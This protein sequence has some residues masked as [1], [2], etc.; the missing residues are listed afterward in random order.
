MTPSVTD[1]DPVFSND[2]PIAPRW[3]A[4]LLVWLGGLLTG[5]SLVC[6]GNALGPSG[7]HSSPSHAHLPRWLVSELFVL[8]ISGLWT[9]QAFQKASPAKQRLYRRGAAKAGSPWRTGAYIA[10]AAALLG[11]LILSPGFGHIHPGWA[12]L[13]LAIAM[14]YAGTVA[15]L[16]STL[17]LY[18]PLPADLADAKSPVQQAAAPSPALSIPDA[19]V[20]GG[21]VPGGYTAQNSK[22]VLALG[23]SDAAARSTLQWGWAARL[24]VWLC[25]IV[26]A[27]GFAM[28]ATS[29][30]PDP[31]AMSLHASAGDFIT[32]LICDALLGS[33]ISF[34]FVLGKSPVMLL[35]M[36]RLSSKMGLPLV[37]ALKIAGGV[38][39]LV[40]VVCLMGAAFGSLRG[41]MF[42]HIGRL[43]LGFPL[44]IA[45]V[46]GM[47]LAFRRAYPPL[48]AGLAGKSDEELAAAVL[49]SV[50]KGVMPNSLLW[51]RSDRI[52]VFG[53]SDAQRRGM[54]IVAALPAILVA[55]VAISTFVLA[56]TQLL[57]LHALTPMV[58][59]FAVGF[60]V[61]ALVMA[62]GIRKALVTKFEFDRV[63]RTYHQ[64]TVDSA[65]WKVPPRRSETSMNWGA[66]RVFDG[67]V[68]DDM[69]GV[70]LSVQTGGRQNNWLWYQVVVAWRDDKHPAAPLS[71]PY[72][73]E[74]YAISA[75]DNIAAL[76][77]VPMLGELDIN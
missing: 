3:K 47:L 2:A 74:A 35:N 26:A 42:P 51:R 34:A 4:G 69:L 68:D 48:T 9:A 70:G 71:Q 41:P 39:A 14:L 59:F 17:L 67:A 18:P 28:I 50:Y 5:Q 16:S 76:L 32:L 15:T 54:V 6:L 25:S 36:R 38:F 21:V 46:C 40:A 27:Q 60:V 19:S 1:A 55:G 77:G 52:L 57:Q 64:V 61:F 30:A 66:P 8:V 7:R 20:K 56:Q 31:I 63:T 62:I 49:Q 10:V 37:A 11:A 72:T 53:P 58:P 12:M 29:T 75:R 33:L 45:S 13:A 23:L 44:L 65:G 43:E 22:E 24:A 73:S